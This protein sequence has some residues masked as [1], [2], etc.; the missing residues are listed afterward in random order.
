MRRESRRRE[1]ITISA[2]VTVLSIA[3][4]TTAARAAQPV[5][6]PA[7]KPV[8]GSELLSGSGHIAIA[9]AAPG[10]VQLIS[11]STGNSLQTDQPG[12]VPDAVSAVWLAMTCRTG[13]RQLP[14]LYN[15]PQG[16][17]LPL[18]TP[19]SCVG[20]SCGI[21]AI[22]THWVALSPPCS[23]P[24]SKCPSTFEF[25]NLSTGATR[26]DPTNATTR[27]DL[28]AVDL[29]VRVCQPLS[30]PRDN[31]HIEDGVSPG[32]GSLTPD[33]QYGIEAGGAGVF[34]Q[35][36]GSR[37]R[38]LLTR[39]ASSSGCAAR[40]CPPA[41]NREM[42]LWQ[43]AAGR[44]SGVLLKGLRRFD[45]AVP[46][47]VDPTAQQ[48]KYVRADPYTYALAGKTLY[49]QTPRGTIWSASLPIR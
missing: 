34:L 5:Y 24:T 22:G 28:D 11:T 41:R 40:A 15:I 44:L 25:E 13:Y 29:A 6:H 14:F 23:Q 39:T 42:V 35:R 21:A 19:G 3:A 49:L 18:P 47:S 8:A 37:V 43:S 10:R 20:G 2:L 48:L 1:I 33:G 31:Q 26:T 17:A 36:C 9:G 16:R 32:W 45:I 38:S 7:F 27:V 46:A 4:A 12:C 30:V